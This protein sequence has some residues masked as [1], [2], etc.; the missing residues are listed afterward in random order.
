MDDPK[1][2][3]VCILGVLAL[4]LGASIPMLLI[5]INTYN[6]TMESSQRIIGITAVLFTIFA[7]NR[8][9]KKFPILRIWM[10]NT[11]TGVVCMLFIF[12]FL[13]ALGA[14]I[15]ML[16]PF[17]AWLHLTISVILA[18]IASG[19]LFYALMLDEPK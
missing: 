4:G 12:G 19:C 1:A 18:I 7:F 16:V 10:V 5:E 2:A 3:I 8:I 13:A 6:S 11:I 9:G 17:P 15:F 14:K